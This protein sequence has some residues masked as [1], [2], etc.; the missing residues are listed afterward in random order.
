M[1]DNFELKVL[2]RK[3]SFSLFLF[4]F[5]PLKKDMYFKEKDQTQNRRQ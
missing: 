5:A 2:K 3:N 1:S 4:D